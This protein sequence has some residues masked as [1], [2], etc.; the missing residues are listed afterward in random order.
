MK[1]GIDGVKH[2]ER[3]PAQEWDNMECTVRIDSEKD[4]SGHGSMGGA[5]VRDDR[6]DHYIA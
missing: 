4:F 3:L 6:Y 1:T 2:R 5:S